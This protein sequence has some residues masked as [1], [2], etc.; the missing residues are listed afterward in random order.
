MT[1]GLDGFCLKTLI[2]LLLSLLLISTANI[3]LA[4]TISQVLCRVFSDWPSVDLQG[5]LKLRG[6]IKGSSLAMFF[7]I[8]KFLKL[9][10]FKLKI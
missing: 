7:L 6:V 8:Y 5:L 2:Y 9:N 10:C 3:Y 1:R 4:L